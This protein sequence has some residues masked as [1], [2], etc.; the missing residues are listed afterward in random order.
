[1]V[2]DTTITSDAPS[3]STSGAVS[4]IVT[5]VV[6]SNAANSLYSYVIASPIAFFWPGGVENLHPPS[7]H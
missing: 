1:M 2:N 4:V 5:T 3:G 7:R 6:G